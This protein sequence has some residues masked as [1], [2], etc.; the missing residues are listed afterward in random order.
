MNVKAMNKT[1][2]Y[3]IIEKKL[4]RAL[5]ERVLWC[6]VYFCTACRFQF[7]WAYRF[8]EGIVSK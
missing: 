4:F 8:P 3:L 6:L 5:I 7:M 2:T 1:A